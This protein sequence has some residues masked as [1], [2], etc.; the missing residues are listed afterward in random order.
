MRIINVFAILCAT[1]VLSGC[2]ETSLDCSTSEAKSLV[3]QLVDGPASDSES[4]ERQELTIY[5][6][7]MKACKMGMVSCPP[8]YEKK[9]RDLVSHL[10]DIRTI[11]KTQ[12]KSVCHSTVAFNSGSTMGIEYFVTRTD[13]GRL[14]VTLGRRA[15]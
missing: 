12:Y 11:D 2:G 15:Y 14:F 7:K 10:Q 5:N 6:N 1:L 3:A 9:P 13:D 8:A 4:V